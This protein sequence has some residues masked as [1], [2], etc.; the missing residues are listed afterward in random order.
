VTFSI[1]YDSDTVSGHSLSE[2]RRRTHTSD[3]CWGFQIHYLA[4]HVTC[5]KEVTVQL[6]PT[7]VPEPCTCMW[8]SCI[9][10]GTRASLFLVAVFLFHQACSSSGCWRSVL[11]LHSVGSDVVQTY[12]ACDGDSSRMSKTIAIV[13]AV[14]C[15]PTANVSG[16]TDPLKNLGR[17]PEQR[18]PKRIQLHLICVQESSIFSLLAR[19]ISIELSRKKI[20]GSTIVFTVKIKF[21]E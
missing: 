20:W 11:L 7:P 4:M 1:G 6:P 5:R 15:G 16:P 13:I 10:E 14:F 2:K 17:C 18:Q 3:H 21:E 12:H 9:R 19:K 8:Q